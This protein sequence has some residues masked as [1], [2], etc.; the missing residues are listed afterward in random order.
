M[1]RRTF[2]ATAGTLFV[3]GCGGKKS[4]AERR[5]QKKRGYYQKDMQFK[6]R[7]PPEFASSDGEA[8]EFEDPEKKFNESTFDFGLSDKFDF[9]EEDRTPVET[10]PKATAYLDTVRAEL[11]DA[12][13]MYVSY[14]GPDADIS[15]VNPTLSSFS[16][17]RIRK[18]V[19][20]IATPLEKAAQH[21]TEGQMA[22]VAGLQ[23]VGVFL[24]QAPW[25]EQALIDAW[26][27]FTFAVERVYNESLSLANRSVNK[28]K[29]NIDTAKDKL[30]NLEAEVDGQAMVTF[31][32]LSADGFTAKLEQLNA[33]ISFIQD[34]VQA[35]DRMRIG[36]ERMASGVSA[37]ID[38]DYQS[39]SNP[40]LRAG[41]NFSRAERNL[42]EYGNAG[43]MKEKAKEVYNVAFTLEQVCEDLGDA[44]R[45]KAW[46]NR[47]NFYE[48]EE[49]AEEHIRSNDIVTQMRTPYDV[50]Y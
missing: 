23:Q 47:S 26:D 36:M 10:N 8:F 32:K 41:N 17:L 13:E 24:V 37:Y 39:A 44:A 20:G 21:A 42:D 2:L 49:D 38:E 31:P 45:A 3:A 19:R 14:A 40:L 48:N 5:R 43:P 22:Y 33:E 11:T 29:H 50:I 35:V 12:Y 6:D 7:T 28:A 30:R 25:V 9:G 15:D 46:G 34:F 27:D 4:P 18:K 16:G 1:K